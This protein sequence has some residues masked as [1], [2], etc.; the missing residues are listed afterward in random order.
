MSNAALVPCAGC[1]RHVRADEAACPFCGGS[2]AGAS[3]EGIVP[4]PAQRM[5]RAGMLA[6]ATAFLSSACHPTEPPAPPP[7]PTVADAGSVMAIYGAPAPRDPG[8]Q[9]N[10][11][12]GPPPPQPMT[13]AGLTP[14]PAPTPTP[15]DLAVP[16]YGAPPPAPPTPPTRPTRPPGSVSTRYGAPPRPAPDGL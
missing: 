4:E 15:N 13:D 8:A 11:Y 3:V 10:I 6:F 7:Q 12:G 14:I 9:G 5:S 2:L 16:A 1:H